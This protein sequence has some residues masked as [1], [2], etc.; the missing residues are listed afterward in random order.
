MGMTSYGRHVRNTS[1]G[2][3][4]AWQMILFIVGLLAFL[5]LVS[6]VH[7]ATSPA[8]A[9]IDSQ[10]PRLALVVGNAEYPVAPLK[11]AANDAADMARVLSGLGFDV[12][13]QTNADK[14]GMLTALDEFHLRLKDSG[15][16]GLFY[17]AG[18]GVQ[19]DGRNYLLPVDVRVLAAVDVE[20]E[21]L[22]AA[23]VLGRMEEA[24]N[25]LNIV[26]LDACRDNPFP[27]AFRSP[28]AG[29]A[30]MDAPRGAIVAYA[31]GPGQAALDG[32]GGRNGVYTKHLLAV[33]GLPGLTLEQVFKLVRV[34][35]AQETGERQIPWESSCLMGEFYFS[36]P[37]DA[38]PGPDP[39]GQA[40]VPDPARLA[41]S[42][43]LSPDEPP[44]PNDLQ[45]QNALLA[46]RE[47]DLALREAELDAQAQR[48]ATALAELEGQERPA[49]APGSTAPPD[50]QPTSVQAAS[51]Q[52]ASA[53]P[54]TGQTPETG[55]L[56]GTWVITGPDKHIG[57]HASYLTLTR[58]PEGL[59]AHIHSTAGARNAVLGLIR[60]KDDLIFEWRSQ[61]DQY[62]MSTLV[63]ADLDQGRKA[64][65]SAIPLTFEPIAGDWGGPGRPSRGWLIR[66]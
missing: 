37:R 16:V 36:R 66:Q 38:R 40:A 6:N 60:G 23:R 54:T 39:V 49:T 48:L 33:M 25:P 15:G 27:T 1:L 14:R 44:A 35:V 11:N 30:R 29:L 2:R 4:P 58:T 5:L 45:V 17:Y 26:I 43:A 3:S 19:K 10:A 53:K 52:A 63:R 21:G 31:T 9:R 13:L 28:T 42:E 50:D 64:G 51:V 47:A 61:L 32:R 20:F 56:T 22:D 12:M 7:A 24:G 62:V 59:A 18:H 46:E 41:V 34:R 55:S 57:E 65:Y 8:A